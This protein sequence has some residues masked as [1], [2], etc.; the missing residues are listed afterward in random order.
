M[1]SFNLV[2]DHLTRIS[3]DLSKFVY[4]YQWRV[5]LKL[6]ADAPF[7]WI[8]CLASSDMFVCLL[9]T[10]MLANDSSQVKTRKPQR[11][12]KLFNQ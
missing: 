8:I 10:M 3:T 12:N 7:A 2:D 9:V 11:H 4:S 6:F 5:I 1:S